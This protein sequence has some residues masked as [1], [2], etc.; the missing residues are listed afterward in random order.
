MMT[1]TL[2]IIPTK[3][4]IGP[5]NC[6]I[7]NLIYQKGE[8]DVIVVDMSKDPGLLVFD[9]YFR[10]GMERMKHSGHEYFVARCD[11]NNQHDACNIGLQYA[12]DKGYKLCLCSDDDLIYDPGFIEKGI[13]YMDENPEC[14]VMVGYTFVPPQTIKQQTMQGIM[15]GHKDFTGKIE[16]MGPSGGYYHCV[17]FNPY[18]KEPKEFEVLFG[19]FFFRTEDA[20]RVGG[21]PTHLSKSGFRGELMLE[22]AIGRLGKK[23]I[24]NPELISWHYSN[25]TGGMRSIPEDIRKKNISEDVKK[26]EAFIKRGTADT[27]EVKQ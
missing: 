15:Y 9:K 20:I 24:L 11:G 23:L 8:F 27:K 5:L 26:W 19:G 16:D 22:V 4:R 13:N 3:D 12:V 6:L 2:I 7:Q 1:K 18:I 14:G 21:F 25:P 10:D 17:Y